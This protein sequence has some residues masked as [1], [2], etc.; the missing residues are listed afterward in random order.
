MRT[1]TRR[2][3]NPGE[4]VGGVLVVLLYMVVAPG[5]IHA[6]FDAPPYAENLLF[7]IGLVL[8]VGV[9][10]LLYLSRLRSEP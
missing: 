10:C 7:L 6:Q 2:P 8:L 1:I 4:I 9:V 3:D 5:M